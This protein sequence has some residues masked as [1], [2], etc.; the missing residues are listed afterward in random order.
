MNDD[1]R[2]DEIRTAMM[3]W[4]RQHFDWEVVA[5]QVEGWALAEQRSVPEPSDYMPISDFEGVLL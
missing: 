4:A 3:P 1:E 2:Q 5:D